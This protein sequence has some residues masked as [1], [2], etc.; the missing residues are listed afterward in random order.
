MSDQLKRDDLRKFL[1]DERTIRAFENLQSTVD[2]TLPGQIASAQSLA[3]QALAIALATGD[4]DNSAMQVALSELAA[5][6]AT[7]DRKSVV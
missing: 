6:I 2:L 4:A 1:P 7:A 3:N 5:Q